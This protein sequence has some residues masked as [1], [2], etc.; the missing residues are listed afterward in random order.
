VP[1]VGLAQDW[2]L[3]WHT[4]RH[5]LPHVD[6][7]LTDTVGV[8]LLAKEGIRHARAANLFGLERDWEVCGRMGTGTS[9]YRASP[10]SAATDGLTG[11]SSYRASP[12]SAATDGLE[13]HPTRD[14]DILFVGNLHPAVQKE[15]LPWLVRLARLGRRLRVR[16]LQG[17]PPKEHRRLAQRARIVFNRSVRGECNMRTF[18]AAA[19]GAL[20]FQEAGNRE[21]PAYFRDRQECVCYTEADLEER[22]TYYLEHEE[23]RQAIAQA[24]QLRVQQ[25]SFANL[26]D[27]QVQRLEE[28]WP[29]LLE[30]AQVRQK[31]TVPQKH[32]GDSPLLTPPSLQARLWQAVTNSTPAT[33]TT[34]VADLTTAL[35][36]AATHAELHHALGLARSL[37][38][39]DRQR[40]LEH[41]T[42]AVEQE[43]TH[44]LARLH[45]VEALAALGQQDR[46]VLVA[47]QALEVLDRPLDPGALAA[48]QVLLSAPPYPLGYDELRVAWERAAW[49]HA[50]DRE[51]EVQ[52]KAALVRGRL[53]ALLA[54][55]THATAHWQAAVQACPEQSTARAA[56]GCAL[57]SAGWIAEAVPHLRAAV[58]LNPLDRRAARALYQAFGDSGDTTGQQALAEERA[59]LA[60]AAPQVV[61][62]E[63]WFA[64]R[65]ARAEANALWDGLPSPSQSPADGLGSPSH[66]AAMRPLPSSAVVSGSPRAVS[67][68]PRAVSGSPDPATGPTAGLP[69][70]PHS[71]AVSGSPDPATGPTAG[72]PSRPHSCI[73][74]LTPSEFA[75][76]FGQLD[77]S[78]AIH[79]FTP[80]PDTHVVLT[81]LAHSQARRILEIGTAAG[82]MT[83]NRTHWSPADAVVYSLG[84]TDDLQVPTTAAQRP[85]DPPRA[86]FGRFAN[87]FG[88]AGKVMFITAD[89][90][91]FDFAR[92][93]PLEY[94]FV[95]GAHDLEHVLSDSRNAYEQLQPGGCLVWHDLDN[96]TPWVQV[97]QALEQLPVA[98]PIYH[99]AGTQVAFLHKDG[100]RTDFQSVQPPRG[101]DWKSV[102]RSGL[103]WEGDQLA[104]HSL[105]HVNRSI[106]RQWLLHGHDL[107]LRVTD[108]PGDPVPTLPAEPW[109]QAHRDRA[110]DQPALLHVRH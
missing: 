34:L 45:R 13:A 17:V 76:H 27:E 69:S 16:I 30:R 93:G 105:A 108:R 12:H 109:Q 1:L 66:K 77:T 96:P 32:E 22:L 65:A 87:H 107:A 61:A 9:S 37:M 18:E 42:D 14:I 39:R 54:E 80:P 25:L 48:W 88:K 52:A 3:L 91:Q 75:Q 38:T 98:E 24:G 5:L 8:E 106:C 100:C 28:D 43:P 74:T 101:T 58:Q 72:L 15:R 50:G 78:Q 86:H 60:C 70:R 53:H 79:G 56:L 7:V 90:R 85:E 41:C 2:N 104:V 73:L 97:R 31:G 57:A 40:L 89:S 44:V 94:V 81:L 49:S 62:V 33:D 29:A 110:L 47:R 82:H 64:T 51:G 10:H 102:L 19:A 21:V 4:Y 46:A 92:L 36:G 67:G 84:I 59:L 11:T 6:R 23:E 26:W 63:P 95:D 35:A 20:L 55:R 68:S 99:V 71:R 83:A 103:I